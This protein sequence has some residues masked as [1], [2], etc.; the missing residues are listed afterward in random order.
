MSVH[1]HP[2]RNRLVDTTAFFLAT[3]DP[4][5]ISVEEI[6]LTSGISKGSLY[7]HFEDLAE[8]LEAAEVKQY[9]EWVDKS[10]ETLVGVLAGVK[11]RDELVESLKGVTRA[12][13]GREVLPARIQRA[14]TIAKALNN[15]RF[16][17]ALG[18]EQQRLTSALEDL[19]REAI[20]KGWY[21]S[22]LDPR[23][24]AILIQSYTLGKIVDDIVEDQMSPESWDNLIGQ[25]IERLFLK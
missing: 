2:T 5:T 13:Q 19:F 23:A 16:K 14:R 3:R 12:T 1:P 4:S 20:E 21:R 17:S 18:V 22:E 8:L 25:L 15:P 11:S 10:I 7:H 9:A 24:C 6:L